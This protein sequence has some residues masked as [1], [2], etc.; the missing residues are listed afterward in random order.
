MPYAV[1]LCPE[2]HK[3]QQNHWQ[4]VIPMQLRLVKPPIALLEKQGGAM[5]LA[6]QVSQWAPVTDPVAVTMV[7]V[8]RVVVQA[9]VVTAADRVT[10][11]AQAAMAADREET[12]LDVNLYRIITMVGIPR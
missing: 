2:V 9:Q 10:V 8:D 3:D 6:G 4:G 11:Q 12:D 5:V 1:H 7:L